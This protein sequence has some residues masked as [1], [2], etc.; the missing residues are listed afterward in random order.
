MRNACSQSASCAEWGRSSV[1]LTLEQAL[2]QRTMAG[3]CCVFGVFDGFHSGH[4]FLCDCASAYARG[5]MP[6]AILTFDIDPDELF[7]PDS[8]EKLDTNETRLARLEA[9]ANV[10]VIVL[11]FTQ[12][13]AAQEPEAFL[14]RIFGNACPFAIFVGE[15][16]RFG[17]RAKGDAETMKQW[18]SSRRLHVHAVKLFD[19]DGE[20]VTSTRI[21]ELL[22]QGEMEQVGVCL[23]RPYVMQGSVE[24]GRGEG[25]SMGFATANIDLDR[26]LALPSEGV[27]AG[28]T[29]VDGL[30]YKTALSIG[31]APTFDD[32]DTAYCEAHLLD[33]N[34]DLYGK[35]LDIQVLHWLRPMIKFA[36][37]DELIAT[38]TSNIEWVRANI[39]L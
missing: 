34:G 1:R 8:L 20:P 35:S 28:R 30:P 4:R 37:K 2:E 21:R 39:S 7:S 13:F 15:D 6:F 11:P 27:Y 26:T 16:F 23:G 38:V 36:D 3:A 10:P 9:Y 24:H 22:A 17:A 25:T 18:G 12:E 14:D 33:Y 32:Q 19:Y 29:Y 5:D 31:H